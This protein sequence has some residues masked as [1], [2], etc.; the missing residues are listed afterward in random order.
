M[1]DFRPLEFMGVCLLVIGASLIPTLIVP[2]MIAQAGGVFYRQ[3]IV[4]K[5]QQ[6]DRD[7]LTNYDTQQEQ[8]RRQLEQVDLF[9]TNTP[10]NEI[11]PERLSSLIQLR[12]YVKAE[13]EAAKPPISVIAFHLNPQILLWPGLYATLACLV[14]LLR[15]IRISLRKA[16][17]K[18]VIY[19]FGIYV[20]YQ[21]PLWMRN[22]VLSNEGRTIFAFSNYDIHK[23][24]F[25][26]QEA[27]ILGF[28]FL[29]ATAWWQWAQFFDGRRIELRRRMN[30]TLEGAGNEASE[31]LARTFTQWQICSAVLAG[32]FLFA[33]NFY[34]TIVDR[35]NDPRY[36][37]SAIIIHV[38]WGLTWILISM[39]LA[40]TWLAWERSRVRALETLLLRREDT[41]LEKY[42]HTRQLLTEMRPLGSINVSVSAIGAIVSFL[43]PLLKL[44]RP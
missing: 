25:F 37:I 42:E 44:I 10:Q 29:L 19:A 28:A 38:L 36:L 2:G 5:L 9:L 8:R 3:D 43:L 18:I 17:A 22:F 20:F 14:I 31:R 7:K 40:I 6:G 26:A 12:S 24:S 4:S 27:V 33:T 21:W 39:P 32:G 11:P 15:P 34:W 41:S 30:A 35:Y 13:Y 16:K 23:A 1:E